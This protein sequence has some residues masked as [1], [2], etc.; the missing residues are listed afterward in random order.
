MLAQLAVSGT[1]VAFVYAGDVWTAKLDGSDV[2]RITTADGDESNPV[3]S[4]DGRLLAFAGNYDG[5]VDVYVVPVA[6]GEVRRLTWHPGNDLPQAFTRDGKRVLF[7][8]ET[9][10]TGRSAT[11]SSGPWRPP[12]GPRRSCPYR[13]GRR[14]RIRRTAIPSPTTLSAAPS[15]SGRD[16]PRWRF[17]QLWLINSSGWDVEKVPQPQGHANDVDGMWLDANQ[18]WF[19][20]DREGE[21]NIYRYDRGSKSVTRVTNHT[22]LPVMSAS[23]GGGK[24]VYE[25]GGWLFLLDPMSGKSQKLAISVPLIFARLVPAGSRAPSSCAVCRLRPPAPRSVRDA[26][27]DRHG[28]AEKGDRRNS[29]RRRGRTRSPRR[30]RPMGSRSPSSPTSGENRR[31]SPGRR[32]RRAPRHRSGGAGFYFD[33]QWSPD[34]KRMAWRDNSQ[35]IFV[36]DIATAR[37]RKVAANQV[38]T[39]RVGITAPR[40][41]PTRAGSPIP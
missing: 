32:Q 19:R 2:R 14:Q 41:P 1:H 18:V 31:T 27:R 17:S 37:I 8:L 6:G 22:D 29:P 15:S 13:T 35:A 34:G 40:G 9:A 10:P 25:Q 24:I 11:A 20:S 4:E 16:G 3:L 21:F 23:S 36:M 33:P 12:A 28:P 7:T 26:R 30:G 5:N 39:P 38:Y